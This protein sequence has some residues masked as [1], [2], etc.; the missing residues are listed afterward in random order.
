MRVYI[1][2][3]LEKERGE[4]NYSYLKDLP[5]IEKVK[6]KRLANKK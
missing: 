3:L 5:D 6:K 2:E 1:E 4:M